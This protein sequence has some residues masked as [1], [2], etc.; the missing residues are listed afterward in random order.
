M[1]DFEKTGAEWLILPL[2]TAQNRG[3]YASLIQLLI[4]WQVQGILPP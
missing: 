2:T 1:A 4:H 3:L